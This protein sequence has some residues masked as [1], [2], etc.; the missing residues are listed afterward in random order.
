MLA[1]WVLP[2]ES[3]ALDIRMK[4]PGV[5][6][7]QGNFQRRQAPAELTYCAEVVASTYTAMGLLPP[8]LPTNYYDPGMFWSGDA[9]PLRE[10][11]RLGAEIAVDC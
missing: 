4:W 2:A 11:A 5:D 10:G 8:D 3:I 9:L 7:V 6:G 1:G